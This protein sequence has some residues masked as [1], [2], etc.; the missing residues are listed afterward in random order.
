MQHYKYGFEDYRD[1]YK[2]RLLELL[3]KHGILPVLWS[4][5]NA[6]GGSELNLPVIPSDYPVILMDDEGNQLIRRMRGIIGDAG[7]L[8]YLSELVDEQTPSVNKL[9]D[10]VAWGRLG[11]YLKSESERILTLGLREIE[12]G[13]C[14]KRSAGGDRRLKPGKDFFLFPRLP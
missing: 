11:T 5:K 8:E 9:I 7:V 10:R 2:A 13:D 1:E 4:I 14:V 6:P 12:G 3:K